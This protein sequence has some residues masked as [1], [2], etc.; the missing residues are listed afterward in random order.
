[1]SRSLGDWHLTFR[2]NMVALRKGSK[3]QT[4]K[5]IPQIFLNIKHGGR[6]T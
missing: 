1:M 5:H 3:F 4:R 2:E 6:F